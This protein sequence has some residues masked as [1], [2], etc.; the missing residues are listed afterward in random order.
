MPDQPTDQPIAEPTSEPQVP[1]PEFPDPVSPQVRELLRNRTPEMDSMLNLV[2]QQESQKASSRIEKE[3]QRADSLQKQ[4][5]ESRLSS[6]NAE[7][8]A[9]KS[10]VAQMAESVQQLLD[11]QSKTV[12]ATQALDIGTKRMLLLSQI[13]ADILPPE[14]HSLVRGATEE[15]LQSS[16]QTAVSDYRTMLQRI[17]P[18]G[19]TQPFAQQQSTQDQLYSANPVQPA[20]G[21]SQPENAGPSTE[22][23]VPTVG[24]IRDLQ[25]RA[26]RGDASALQEFNVAASRVLQHE[27]GQR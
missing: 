13:S 23:G 14:M 16:L 25:A 15:E 4:I 19:V 20:T 9:L 27:L 1:E 6:E 12:A 17:T 11:V 2:R 18:S 10:Q 22:V 8:A 3:K 5:D 26:M 24:Q 7:I 21:L